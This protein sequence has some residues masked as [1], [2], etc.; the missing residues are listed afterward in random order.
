MLI[1]HALWK[2]HVEAGDGSTTMAVLYQ[3]ILNEG[4]RYVTQA[5]SNAMLL[6]SGLEAGLRV[7]LE[8]LE[9]EATPLAGK[10][11]LA[12]MARGMCQEDVEMANMLGEIFDIVGPD[13]L[14]LV[15][16]GNRGE[17][18]RE[19]VD[20][21]YWHLSGWLSR[22]FVTDKAE[23]RTT[24]E[25]AAILISDLTI[26]DPRQLVPVLD[27]CAKAGVK[28]LVVICKELSDSTIGLLVT[29]NQAKTI[30]TM[31]V[32][33]PKAGADQVAALEDMAVLTGGRVFYSAAKETF[34][35]FQLEDLG[36]ARRAWAME[37]L[38]GIFGGKGDSRQ[39]RQHIAHIRGMQRLAE[40]KNEKKN[41]QQ[42]LGRLTGATAILRVG[43]VTDTEIEARKVMAERAV[44]AMRS[45]ILGGV[46]PG[47]GAALLNAQSALIGLPAKHAEDTAAYKILARALE[48][49]MR[50]IAHNAG[51]VPEVIVE[52]AKACPKGF[53]FDARSRQIVDLR[54]A[55]IV[56]SV[57]VLKKALE[58]AV[59]G[60]AMALTTD[61]IVH[62]RKLKES[63]EP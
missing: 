48:E 32:R 9:R 38:F 39:V 30:E 4:I 46:V 50:T 45:A 61:V 47:G 37:S 24:F 3:V 57:R 62:H 44:T 10:E 33:A 21:T 35:D 5:G 18:E 63:I 8:A 22:W 7:V 11:Q 34:D 28:K 13:G 49:P 19:Y 56:D 40:S 42:R 16:S 51:S 36:Y 15:E 12:L 25:D 41:L 52:K 17:L 53:G 29:N 60:A 2:M 58:I 31:A 59:S 6:R 43:G 55:G 26:K 54:Q 14:I 23:K 20:G 27:K 1:R